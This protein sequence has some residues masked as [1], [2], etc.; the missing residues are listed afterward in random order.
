MDGKHIYIVP[1]ANSGSVFY[2]FKG[3][4]SVVLFAIVDHNYEFIYVDVGTEGKSSDGG[5]WRECTFKEWLE[6]D[7][8]E[9]PEPR[10]LPGSNVPT[11]PMIV[12][13]D[14]FPLTPNV[15]KPFNR[16]HLSKSEA[17]FNYRLSRAR[18]VAENCFGI[19]ANRFRVFLTN[20][21]MQPDRVV[22]M[23]LAA[24]ILHNL[25]RRRCGKNYI[26]AGS[27]DQEDVDHGLIPGEWRNQY[28]LPK[29]PPPQGRN[30]PILA[31][32][33]RKRL[34]KYFMTPAGEVPWQY[35][36]IKF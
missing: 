12:A 24:A 27:I 34:S 28:Q 4:Y 8:L 5:I 1:P 36:S 33:L 19:L 11:C 7:D 35:D 3:T 2:N 26:P 10:N 15:M 13:D 16:R 14:A 20:I 25:L 6:A 31:K 9:M 17:V 23:V 22:G 21:M 30:T 32:Q 29:I 18:R